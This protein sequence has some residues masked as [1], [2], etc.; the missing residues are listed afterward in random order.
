M[1]PTHIIDEI[2]ELGCKTETITSISFMMED[3]E[4]P[5][6]INMLKH[7]LKAYEIKYKFDGVGFRDC[8]LLIF[9]GEE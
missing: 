1:L 7:L 3:G 6:S 8:K 2:K 5:K 4:L 9:S